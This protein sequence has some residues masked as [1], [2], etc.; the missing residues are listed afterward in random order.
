MNHRPQTFK[1]E[2]KMLR[3]CDW[4]GAYTDCE[5]M[6]RSESCGADG[7]PRRPW[8]V[9]QPDGR[10]AGRTYSFLLR[11]RLPV[12]GVRRIRH[13]ARRH[14]VGGNRGHYSDAPGREI[15]DRRA[16]LHGSRQRRRRGK[17][18]INTTGKTAMNTKHS[19]K[20]IVKPEAT[21]TT[22]GPS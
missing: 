12:L 22:R 2:N 19:K 5:K 7:R 8:C 6:Q 10:S 17:R 15:R 14:D 1:G 20:Y 21:P 18:S 16:V 4:C 3:C 11:P 13:V 9:R